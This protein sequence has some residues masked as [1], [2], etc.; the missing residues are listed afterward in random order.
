MIRPIPLK[1]PLPMDIKVLRVERA[2]DSWRIWLMANGDYSLGTFIQLVD[3]GTVNR[4]TWHN[5]G[6]ES[7]FEVINNAEI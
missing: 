6:T 1:F 5:D 3:D 7:V 4:V 2:K